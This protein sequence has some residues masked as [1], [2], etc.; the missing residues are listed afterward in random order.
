[1]DGRL[2]LRHVSIFVYILSLFD[3]FQSH[4]TS[5]HPWNI[6]A[7][8]SRHSAASVSNKQKLLLFGGITDSGDV[9]SDVWRFEN[10]HFHICF[11]SV[12]PI[13]ANPFFWGP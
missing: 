13:D 9:K 8:F 10:G 1:M 2:R 3:V 4:S 7:F 6:S 12:L 11:F 5:N